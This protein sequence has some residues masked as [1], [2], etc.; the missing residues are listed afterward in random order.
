MTQSFASL[1]LS[2]ELTR[3]VAEQGYTQPTPVQAQVI[4]VI[5]DGRDVR[6]RP[7]IERTN[8]LARSVRHRRRRIRYSEPFELPGAYAYRRAA[9]TGLRAM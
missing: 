9:V 1:G 7:P 4:P 8:E 6:T 5:L 3:A 2:A